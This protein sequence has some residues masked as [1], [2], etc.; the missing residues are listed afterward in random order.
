LFYCLKQKGDFMVFTKSIRVVSLIAG[1]SVL[2]SGLTAAVTTNVINQ[3]NSVAIGS[4]GPAGQDGREVEFQVVNNVMQWRYTNEETWNSLDLEFGGGSTPGSIISTSGSSAFTHWIF[5]EEALTIPFPTFTLNSST[6]GFTPI[7]TLQEFRNIRNNLAG[8]YV[9]TNDID[10]ASL[11]QDDLRLDGYRVVPGTFTGTL[12]GAGFDLLNLKIGEDSGYANGVQDVGVFQ[13][14]Q[15][16]TITD[17]SLNNFSYKL[18]GTESNYIETGGAL[19]GEILDSNTFTTLDSIQVNNF[20]VESSEFTPGDIRV[21]GALAGSVDS[22]ALVRVRDASV[23][24]MLVTLRLGTWSAS[25]EIG[26]LFGRANADNLS[27]SQT[28]TDIEFVNSQYTNGIGGAIGEVNDIT[29]QIDDSD[30]SITGNFTEDVGGMIGDVDNNSKISI[31]NSNTIVDINYFTDSSSNNSGYD[32][33]GLIG[34]L[35]SETITLINQVETSGTING[36]YRL[37]GLIGEV[38]HELLIRVENTTNNIDLS[39][40]YSI[41]GFIGET[42]DDNRLNILISDSENLG[43]IST[44]FSQSN[45]D[46][47]TSGGFIGYLGESD[48]SNKQNQNQVWIRNSIADFDFIIELNID[49]TTLNDQNNQPVII[50]E[51]VDL[52]NYFYSLG[53]AIGEVYDDNIVRLSNNVITTNLDLTVEGASFE[54]G[55]IDIYYVGGLIGT[56]DDDSEVMLLNNTAE[57]NLNFNFSNN[58]SVNFVDGNYGIDLEIYSIGGS[59][60]EFDGISLLDV[61]G[62]YEFNLN[63]HAEDNDLENAYFDLELYEIGG[64]IGYVNSESTIITDSLD[65]SFMLDLS[66]ALLDNPEFSSIAIEIYEIGEVIGDMNGF[67]FFGNIDYVALITF[68]VPESDVSITIDIMDSENIPFTGNYNNFIVI[69]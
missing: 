36:T 64:Y 6:T 28:S 38:D 35:E 14:L 49:E 23:N 61:A 11:T 50:Q 29:L 51:Y 17:I 62:T 53:G 63:L 65:I 27:I 26:G 33:G 22:S 3:E 47:Q 42:G 58:N 19:A 16:A 41:G 54:G 12:N 21:L 1:T 52:N 60:G 39:G 10:F 18:I 67:G 66:V 40:R 7:G 34:N 9:L 8:N 25:G 20:R 5:A 45:G 43:D 59:I 15:G 56:V 13:S 69:T 24:D 37:G 31:T 32:F 30:F 44:N 48:T 57:L 68:V 55:Y 46:L 2:L 4:Q